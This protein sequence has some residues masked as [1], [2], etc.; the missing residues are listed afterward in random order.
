VCV[1]LALLGAA[2]PAAAQ[3]TLVES[4]AAMR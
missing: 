2:T 1:A 4:G 3:V